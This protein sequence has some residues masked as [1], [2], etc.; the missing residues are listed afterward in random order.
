MGNDKRGSEEFGFA[1][2]MTWIKYWGLQ[3][4]TR[5]GTEPNPAKFEGK[6]F[7]G[8]DPEGA[9]ELVQNLYQKR[10]EQPH[11]AE[12]DEKTGMKYDNVYLTKYAAQTS[13]AKFIR[14]PAGPVFTDFAQMGY[15]VSYCRMKYTQFLHTQLAHCIGNLGE[16]HPTCQKAAWYKAIGTPSVAAAWFEEA[17]ELGHFD[18]TKKYGLKPHASFLPFYQPVKTQIPGAYEFYRSKSYLDGYSPEGD[19]DITFPIQFVE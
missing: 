4:S 8:Q 19:N 6:W 7:G 12:H 13:E 1:E 3:K 11:R 18:L 16:D 5:M 15:T 10:A 2:P 17:D 9:D 14:D